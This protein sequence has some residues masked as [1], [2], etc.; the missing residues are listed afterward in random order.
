MDDVTETVGSRIKSA[1][2][3]LG[4]TQEDLGCALKVTRAAVAQ[5]EAG[6][7]TPRFERLDQLATV[8]DVN[9]SWLVDGSANDLIHPAQERARELVRLMMRVTGWS[10][11]KL[12]SRSGLA[13][14]TL[15]R[16]MNKPVKHTLSQRTITTLLKTTASNMEDAVDRGVSPHDMAAV[17]QAIEFY[18][19]D[20]DQSLTASMVADHILTDDQFEALCRAWDAAGEPARKKFAHWLKSTDC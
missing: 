1:R 17:A 16:F 14:S 6:E 11:T 12:A 10:T 5:W 19:G 8:L 4:L 7:S 2:Q 18:T 9:K 20:A 3:R 13:E 15:N